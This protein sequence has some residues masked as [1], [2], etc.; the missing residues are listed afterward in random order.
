MRLRLVYALAA[1]LLFG[2][3]SASDLTITFTSTKKGLG[4]SATPGTEIHY[5][6]SSFL[7]TR[8]VEA[9]QDALVDFQQGISYTINHPKKTIAKMS[10]D[11]AMAVMDSM[12]QTQNPAANKMMASMFGDPN[13]IKVTKLAAEKIAGRDCQ[14]WQ[15]SLG[16][17][18][19][20]LAADPTLKAPMPETAYARMMKSRAAQMAQSGP[21]GAAY[22]RLYEEMAKVKGIPLRTHMTGL[23]GVDIATLATRIETGPIPASTFVLPAGYTVEDMGKKMREKMAKAPAP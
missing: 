19:M 4:G 10:F 21:M 12:N 6:A 5:Y 16:K 1:T 23:M 15:I 20:E 2:A 3:L 18:T 7:M 11:D 14:A 17:L 9:K 22:K 13:A 8:T